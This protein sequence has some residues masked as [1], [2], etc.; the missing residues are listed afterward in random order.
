MPKEKTKEKIIEIIN[1]LNPYERPEHFER[2]ENKIADQILELFSQEKQKA[3]E[4][5]K[6]KILAGLPQEEDFVSD[7]LRYEDTEY[8]SNSVRYGRN[9]IIQEIRKIINNL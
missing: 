4:E 6:E 3:R 2:W 1:T 9:E 7:I 5:I 8:H